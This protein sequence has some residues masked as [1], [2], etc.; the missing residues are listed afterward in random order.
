MRD[1]WYRLGVALTGYDSRKA[2]AEF[3]ALQKAF[4]ALPQPKTE[5]PSTLR[6]TKY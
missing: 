1:F 6:K 3:E 5:I 4:D 2:N